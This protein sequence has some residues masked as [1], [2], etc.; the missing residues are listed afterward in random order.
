MK[1]KYVT[2]AIAYANADPHLGHAYEYVLSD[3]IVRYLRDI[4]GAPTYFLTG[5]D[6]HGQKIFEKAKIENLPTKDFVDKYAKVFQ[7]LDSKLQVTYD[8]FIRTTDPDH[9]EVAQKVW[10]KILSKGDL[11]EKEYSGLY[12]VGCEEFKTEK[13][14]VD[15]NC[16]IHLKPVVTLSEKNWF[17]R[18]SKYTEFLKDLIQTNKLKIVPEFRKNEMLEFIDR[19]LQDVSFSRSKELMSWGLP[20]PNDDTQVMYVWCDA[21]VNYITGAKVYGKDEVDQKFFESFWTEGDTLHVIGKDILRFHSLYWPAMLESA[22]LP[23]PKE[24]LVHGFITSGGHKM[25]KSLGNVI[26]PAEIL[27]KYSQFNTKSFLGD[28][29]SSEVFRY[30]F[31]KNIN[32]HDDGDFTYFRLEEL[33]NADLANGLGNLVS[34]VMRLSEKYLDKTDFSSLDLGKHSELT[35]AMKEYDVMKAM[36]YIW[37]LISNLD[38][39]MQTEQP[40]KVIKED[41]ERG[42]SQLEYLREQIFIIAELLK[43]FM[44]ET[45]IKIKEILESNTMPELPLFPRYE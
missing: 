26:L 38:Q 13:D 6:E 9:K 16:P 18:L 10:N 8:R 11:Y 15:G 45:S 22:E 19:G 24:I 17:F 3:A 42:K 43:P 1:N 12:C 2:T 33:Y 40:F 28:K 36:S 30:F 37:K 34:R 7:D 5:M 25:S 35:E 14:L 39:F 32:P 23:I 44:P 29:F 4:L 27:E 20:V 41:L 31:L 21:L